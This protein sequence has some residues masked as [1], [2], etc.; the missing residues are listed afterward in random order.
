MASSSNLGVFHRYCRCVCRQ[1]RGEVGAYESKAANRSAGSRKINCNSP[2]PARFLVLLSLSPPP[3]PLPLLASGIFLR[4]AGPPG[5]VQ[6][7]GHEPQ[8]QPYLPRFRE[9]AGQV[10]TRGSQRCPGLTTLLPPLFAG[11]WLAG[12]TTTLV[13]CLV[14][15]CISRQT[16]LLQAFVQLCDRFCPDIEHC[17]RPRCRTAVVSTSLGPRSIFIGTLLLLL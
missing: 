12:V 8:H 7:L 14:R 13:V 15:A 6:V 2:P 5:G 16:L 11:E 3:A 1:C 17:S 10:Y 9:D 4:A